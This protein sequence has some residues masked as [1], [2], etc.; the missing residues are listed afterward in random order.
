MKITSVTGLT[1]KRF[2]KSKVKYIL[3]FCYLFSFSFIL[4]Y[5]NYLLIN[6]GLNLRRMIFRIIACVEHCSN[7]GRNVK[8]SASISHIREPVSANKS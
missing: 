8:S 3:Q 6:S 1:L 4:K 7:I 5:S 2:N